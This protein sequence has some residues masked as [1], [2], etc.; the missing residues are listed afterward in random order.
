MCD[1][2]IYTFYMRNKV[3]SFKLVICVENSYQIWID[4]AFYLQ[5][6]SE[7]LIFEEPS[8]IV[9]LLAF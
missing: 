3:V 7:G 4:I 8:D 9:Q 1:L 6:L 2:H 5:E